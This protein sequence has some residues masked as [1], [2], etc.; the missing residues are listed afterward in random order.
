MQG[1]TNFLLGSLQAAVDLHG[2]GTVLCVIQSLEKAHV[3]KLESDKHGVI[4]NML[5]GKIALA[6]SRRTIYLEELIPTNAGNISTNFSEVCRTLPPPPV[7][8]PPKP[9]MPMDGDSA[10]FSSMDGLVLCHDSNCS[11]PTELLAT[12]ELTGPYLARESPMHAN[13]GKR[14]KLQ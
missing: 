4:A 3:I 2:E 7:G 13:T 12:A 9:P 1:M 10:E 11:N 5:F 6:A 14:T 8:L